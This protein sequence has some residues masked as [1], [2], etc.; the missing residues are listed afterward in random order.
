M[1]RMPWKLAGA[2][3]IGYVVL[4]LVSVSIGSKVPELGASRAEVVADF[5]DGSAS[6]MYAAIYVTG[7]AILVFASVASF[8]VQALRDVAASGWAATTAFAAAIIY[9]ATNAADPALLGALVYGGHHGADP[10]SLV[11]LNDTRNVMLDSSFLAL[12]AFTV[13]AAIAVLRADVL[14]SWIAYFGL[15]SGVLL[16]V[17]MAFGPAFLLNMVW[18]VA[19]GIVMISKRRDPATI[20]NP[21]VPATV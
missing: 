4:E 13:L 19:F 18:M 17:P 14:P 16:A 9:V 20:G 7:L 15:V 12:G 1:A 5:S 11:L 3:A 6:K 10:A 2:L 21:P 8:L